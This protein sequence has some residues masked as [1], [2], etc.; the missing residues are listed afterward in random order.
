MVVSQLA[1]IVLV[2]LHGATLRNSKEVDVTWVL[3][4]GALVG[5][6]HA[7]QLIDHP[8]LERRERRDIHRRDVIV[9]LRAGAASAPS[10]AAARCS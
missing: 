10:R 8:E 2:A 5:V 7:L 4:F 3:F 1:Y 9:L 6:A